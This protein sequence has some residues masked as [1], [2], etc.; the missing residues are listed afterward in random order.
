MANRETITL[1]IRRRPWFEWMLWA[2]WAVF[3][4]FLLQNAVASA[5]EF[6]PRA[7]TI[8]W[9]LFAVFLAGGLIVWFARRAR[10]PR[11]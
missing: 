8:F 2:M 1:T 11:A 10:S 6:E 9:I 7:S 4:C 3:E 5:Q